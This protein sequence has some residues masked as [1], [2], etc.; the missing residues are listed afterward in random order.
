MPWTNLGLPMGHNWDYIWD[1][2]GTTY[3]TILGLHMGLKWDYVWDYIGTDLG[4]W[5]GCM[6]YSPIPKQV[7]PLR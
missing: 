1:C 6:D 2:L 3:G 4:L 5:D 7:Y